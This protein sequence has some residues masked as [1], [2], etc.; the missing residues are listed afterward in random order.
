[1]R[2]S[3]GFTLIEVMIAVAIVAIL[4]AIALPSYAEY[5]KRARVIDATQALSS[6]RVKME[7]QFQDRRTWVGACASGTISSAPGRVGQWDVTCDNL[8]GD[9]YIVRATGVA[10]TT[11]ANAKYEINQSNQRTTAQL[12]DGWTAN[13]N[14]GWVL[15]KDGS[16]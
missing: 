13:Q 6:M 16:C 7:Q 2:R 11:M 3:S 5:I 4:A 9:T 8:G 15:K 1:M 12:P 10:G 14:C